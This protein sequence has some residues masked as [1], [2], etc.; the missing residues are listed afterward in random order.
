LLVLKDLSATVRLIGGVAA[1]STLRLLQK[2]DQKIAHRDKVNAL[3]CLEYDSPHENCL[4]FGVS[5]GNSLSRFSVKKLVNLI[6]PKEIDN[7][8]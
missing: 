6:C 3:D 5:I 7:K 4:N 1:R 8:E 2:T